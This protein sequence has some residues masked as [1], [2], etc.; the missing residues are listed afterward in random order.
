MT[1]SSTT[2]KN[3][4]SG[5]G[6]LKV[7]AYTFRILDE[8][9]IKVEIK[10]VNG[11]ITTQTI[12][13]EYTVSGVDADAGGNITFVTA[14]AAT[15][16]VIFTRNVPIKQE[17][18]Y[19]ENA[20][21]PAETHEEALDELTMISQQL[22]EVDSRS[23]KFDTGLGSGFDTVISSDEAISEYYL[24]V[25][26]AAD[27]LELV[28]ASS[29]GLTA[30]VADTTPQ[31]GGDLDA[32]SYNIQFDDNTG[33]E[34]DAGNE[35]LI[36]QKTLNAV[37]HYEL[38]NAITGTT[39][40]FGTA[41]DDVSIPMGFTP[42]GGAAIEFNTNSVDVQQDI[43]HIGDTDTKVTFGTDTLE[44][45]TG[46]GS[47][48]DI[49]DSG[50]RIGGAN[51]RVTA[52]LD[53]DDLVSDSDTSLATQ[54]SIKAYV[55]A[56]SSS[57]VTDTTPQLG[58]DLD[59][60]SYDIQFDDATGIRDDSDNEHLIFQ[61]TAGAVN[62]FEITN[63]I[64]AGGPILSS[65]GTDLNVDL[66][67]ATKGSG[68]VNVSSDIEITDKISHSGDLDNYRSFGTDTQD[69]QTG[70]SSR[71]DISDSGVRLGGAN[72]R[73]TT[74]LD[75]DAMGSDSATALATQQSIKAYVDGQAFGIPNIVAD[76]TPQLGGDLDCNS[77]DIQFDTATG[78]RDDSDNEQLIF[79]KAASAVNY[80]EIQNNATGLTPKITATGDDTNVDMNLATKGT[81]AIQIN[82]S[83]AKV[84]TILDE[85]NM[86]SD[87]ANALATQQSIKAYVDTVGVGTAATQAQQEA[88]TSTTT[89]VSPGRQ[90]FHPSAAKCFINFNGTGTVATRSSYNV[91][92]LNDLGTGKYS[93]DMTTGFSNGDNGT[94]VGS[95]NDN[96]AYGD[97][98]VSTFM[99]DADTI[100]ANTGL[101]AS[102][103]LYDT[104]L[105]T[106]VGFGDFA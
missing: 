14:P 56:A 43:R 22:D 61:K 5:T 63:Q 40:I 98:Q 91:S 44:F 96:T 18:D 13:T 77:Y 52:I 53:E 38:T 23:L 19:R 12:T 3:T 4:Y 36:F 85:D 2:N 72:S 71:L 24:R 57:L 106:V 82:G 68:T 55:D 81:G 6:S 73:V 69:F 67:L 29:S 9:H 39:P 46:G 90:H 84:D 74:I 60:N 20:T 28:A 50:V 66:E 25:N 59:C 51:T 45:T 105:V 89:Y 80:F 75:E 58:G 16:T 87:D 76:T 17:T 92:T 95:A 101:T 8:S 100:G 94:A 97:R 27:G 11:V 48:L 35:Q 15:D 49:S 42:K 37:N 103:T 102:T 7:F 26:T 31:L 54:Q 65:N 93:V 21:F 10:D 64:T 79:A 86:A 41:G 30:I 47:R 88:A 32:N 62:Y 34:D 104:T 70:G 78:I 99:L 83:S 33:I 1:I